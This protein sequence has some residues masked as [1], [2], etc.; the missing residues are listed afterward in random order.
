MCVFGIVIIF[1]KV[2]FLRVWFVIIKISA[3]LDIT[4]WR[5]LIVF[6]KR[7]FSVIIPITVTPFSIYAIGPCFNSPAAYASEC[8]YEISL[9]FNEPSRAEL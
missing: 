9:S 3:P 1:S 4:S 2:S 7:S 8:I 5:L 6:S